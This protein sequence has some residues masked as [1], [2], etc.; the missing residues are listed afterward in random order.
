MPSLPKVCLLFSS[1]SKRYADIQRTACQSKITH[2]LGNG[3]REYV[4][5][6]TM[7]DCEF[8]RAQWYGTDNEAI[9][10]HNC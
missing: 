5:I 6:H 3:R 7:Y 4:L 9:G 10:G 2:G 1:Q 8:V